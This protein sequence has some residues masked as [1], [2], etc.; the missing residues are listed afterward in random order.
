MSPFSLTPNRARRPFRIVA[1]RS[2]IKGVLSATGD[3]D[4][5]GES[6]KS[7]NRSVGDKTS[8]PPEKAMKTRLFVLVGLAISFALPIYAQQKDVADPQT[9][10]NI[11][12]IFKA[13][14]EA[15]KNHDPAAYAANFTR[16]AVFVT[17]TGPIIGRQAIQKYYTDLYQ[18]HPIDFGGKLDGNAFH[19]IG[20]AGNEARATGEWSDTGPGKNGEPITIKGYWSDIYVREGDDWRIR[21]TAFNVTPDSVLLIN[22][23]FPQQLAATPSSTASPSNQQKD[24]AD[25]KTTQKFFADTKGFNEAINNNDAAAIAACFTSD[26]VFVTTGGTVTGRQAIQRWYTDLSSSCTPRTAAAS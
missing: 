2:L 12:A 9:S 26:A 3:M 25:P 20:T 14:N 1:Q 19:M 17:P 16:D 21:V 6:E 11:A 7:R 13:L 8:K 15:Q 5:T 23:N 4:V 18:W 22:K 24:L 10:Q